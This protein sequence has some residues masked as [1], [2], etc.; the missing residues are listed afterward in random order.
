MKTII[1]SGTLFL[2]CSCGIKQKAHIQRNEYI[3]TEIVSRDSI[4]MNRLYQQLSNRRI[5]V[6]HIELAHPDTLG[7]QSVETITDIIIEEEVQ[8]NED[9]D[10][11]GTSLRETSAREKREVRQT[12][13]SVAGS[14]GMTFRQ[15]LFILITCGIAFVLYRMKMN[16]K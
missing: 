9:T 11:G 13:E 16:N 5:S 12:T 8:E 2:L 14:K 7:R 4:N 10:L 1:I 3:Q 15:I 6:K